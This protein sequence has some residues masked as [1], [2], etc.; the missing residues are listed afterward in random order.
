MWVPRSTR[1][2]RQLGA[3]AGS[4]LDHGG[5][6]R[7]EGDDDDGGRAGG[8]ADDFLSPLLVQFLFFQ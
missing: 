4:C 3:L 7:G 1:F 8:E 5:D 2:Q 6:E